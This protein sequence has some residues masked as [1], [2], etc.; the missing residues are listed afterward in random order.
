VRSDLFF[1]PHFRVGE[2]VNPFGDVLVYHHAGYDVWLGELL[3]EHC[4]LF[5]LQ[6]R[7]RELE[8]NRRRSNAVGQR[9]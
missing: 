3:L 8:V 9:L 7:M 2:I 4:L 1:E 5:A 6:M